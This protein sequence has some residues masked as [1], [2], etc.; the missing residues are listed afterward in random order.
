MKSFTEEVNEI[1]D[2]L[3]LYPR[4]TFGYCNGRN[5]FTYNPNSQFSFTPTQKELIIC[6]FNYALYHYNLY[7]KE[8]RSK[9]ELKQSLL[10]LYF[11]NKD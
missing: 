7:Y 5:T 3:L 8:S 11:N 2:L 1:V 6:Y 9:E 10:D 4:T